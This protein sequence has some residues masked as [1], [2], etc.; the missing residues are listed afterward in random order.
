M[1]KPIDYEKHFVIGTPLVGWKV[2]RNEHNQWISHISDIQSKF[3]NAKFF[4]A[5]EVDSRG[6][7]EY[8][9]FIDE[10]N[11]LGIDFWTYSINDNES[12][13]T[14]KNRRIL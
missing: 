8:G 13:V 6:I 12:I 3:P 5:L 1:L 7:S 2:A 4:A 14:S 11:D 10:L 9:H